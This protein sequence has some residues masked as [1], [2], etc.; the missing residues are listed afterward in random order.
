MIRAKCSQIGCA[1]VYYMAN[2]TKNVFLVCNYSSANE[3]KEPIY[4]VGPPCSACV[5]GCSFTCPGLCNTAEERYII[6]LK[7]NLLGLKLRLRL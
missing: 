5:A 7:V 6:N 4:E 1:L 3:P 2:S